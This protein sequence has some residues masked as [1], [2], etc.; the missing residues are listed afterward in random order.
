MSELFLKL[1][2]PEVLQAGRSRSIQQ[3]SICQEEAFHYLLHAE[4]KRSERTGQ[5]YHIIL[6]YRVEGHGTLKPMH[7]YVSA[8]VFDALTQSL[9]QTDYIG[10][11][12]ENHVIGGVLTVVEEDSIAD[13]FERIQ[14]RLKDILL[15]TCGLEESK[16]F[17]FELCRQHEMQDLNA[18]FS[19]RQCSDVGSC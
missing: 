13:V 12:R 6:I 1:F 5:A 18:T 17:R 19:Q 3:N 4:S 14:R 15:S 11:Y 16:Y 7:S 2:T 9:R 8:I 10:W